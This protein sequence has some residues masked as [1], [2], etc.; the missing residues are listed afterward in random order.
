MN[1]AFM[2][3]EFAFAERFVVPWAAGHVLRDVCVDEERAA[4]LEVHVGVA[5]VG[6][7]FA[8]SFHFGAVKDESRFHLF[9]DVVVVRSRAVL[10]DDF[11]ARLLGVLALLRA[12]L[13]TTLHGFTSRLGHNLSFYLMMRLIRMS[14]TAA[15]PGVLFPSYRFSVRGK[16]AELANGIV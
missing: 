10:R 8:Q 4:G 3:K 11:F 5:D 13:G 2:K 6:L 14:G 15:Q 12:L 16:A 7:A 1:L 9:E